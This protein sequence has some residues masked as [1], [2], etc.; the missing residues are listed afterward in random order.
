MKT[1]LTPFQKQFIERL[2]ANMNLGAGENDFQSNADELIGRIGKVITQITV[3]GDGVFK[4]Q[5]PILEFLIDLQRLINKSKLANSPMPLVTNMFRN[6]LDCLRAF[7]YV[8]VIALEI[9]GT[10]DCDTHSSLMTLWELQELV[11]F[12][13]REEKEAA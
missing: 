9:N 6:E 2:I 4:D 7:R 10:C 12:P 5:E 3:D 13:I 11:N 1:K 8:S